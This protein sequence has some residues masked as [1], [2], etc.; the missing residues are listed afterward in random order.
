[1]RSRRR[2][3]LESWRMAA[4][5]KS[6]RR[7]ELH[8]L[9]RLESSVRR[10]AVLDHGDGFLARTSN[11]QSKRSARPEALAGGER[12]HESEHARFFQIRKFPAPKF[13]VARRPHWNRLSTAASRYFVAGRNFLLHLSFAFLHARTLSRRAPTHA[14][15][16]RF[17]SRGFVF[18]AVGCRSNC[19]RR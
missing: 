7:C 17:Y 18:P 1:F 2:S 4:P 13:P 6:A 19:P 8:F 3:L 12:L 10:A 11:R 14:L 9:R 15:A 5:K 16:P